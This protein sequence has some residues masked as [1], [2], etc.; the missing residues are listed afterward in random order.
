M[1]AV[2]RGVPGNDLAVRWRDGRYETGENDT[3]TLADEGD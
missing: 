1:T 2:L 3:R